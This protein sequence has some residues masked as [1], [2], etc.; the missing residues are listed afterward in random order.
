MQDGSRHD[1]A[2]STSS[3][4]LSVGLVNVQNH[5][6]LGDLAAGVLAVLTSAGGGAE[7]DGT[8]KAAK[9]AAAAS[10]QFASKWLR[11]A[12]TARGLV[13]IHVPGLGADHYTE[14][15]QLLPKL[16]KRFGSKLSVMLSP[17]GTTYYP[18]T[19]CYATCT[20]A[21]RPAAERGVGGTLKR[22]RDTAAEATDLTAEEG[23]APSAANGEP[24]VAVNAAVE[25]AQDDSSGDAPADGEVLPL[26]HLALTPLQMLEAGYPVPVAPSVPG[27]PPRCPPGYVASQPRN[28]LHGSKEKQTPRLFA[29]DCEM[30]CTDASGL[31]LARVTVLDSQGRAVLDRFV[32]PLHPV[33]DYVTRYS[34]VAPENLEGEPDDG[35]PSAAG[36]SSSLTSP[37]DQRPLSFARA[38]ACVLSLIAEDDVL[39]GHSLE[40]DLHALRLVHPCVIDTSCLYKSRRGPPFKPGLR[41]LC[42]SVLGRMIQQE[43]H[44]S[45]EDARAALHLVQHAARA[46]HLDVTGW[47]NALRNDRRI[48]PWYAPLGASAPEWSLG[49]SVLSIL[50]ALGTACDVIGSD[51]LV[52]RLTS[53]SS[54]VGRVV[55]R[56][57]HEGGVTAGDALGVAAANAQMSAAVAAVKRLARERLIADGEEGA[58]EDGGSS[59]DG[60]A[61][62]SS[63]SMP[64]WFAHVS[65]EALGHFWERRADRC[66][67]AVRGA[68][69]EAD[70][71]LG[72]SCTPMS[73]DEAMRDA[74]DVARRERQ[75]SATESL[76]HALAGIDGAI[77]DVCMALPRGVAVVVYSGQG[78]T[79]SA[80]LLQERRWDD[81][82][83]RAG[84]PLAGEMPGKRQ[85]GASN[86]SELTRVLNR[87]RRGL[88]L[89]KASDDWLA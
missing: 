46:M 25:G 43:N 78:D 36:N 9:E 17:S 61:S 49:P 71:R 76:K 22:M 23:G 63:L 72:A 29:M 87:A 59:G 47:F 44:D 26:A 18:A 75:R 86:E 70:M 5:T 32:K 13:A 79:P 37:H 56:A 69:D 31:E 45:A 51:A 41:E 62:C 53:T 80:R 38:R 39:V 65:L 11:K 15:A 40:S 66:R 33:V 28:L 42:E 73:R 85:W 68:A 34:G 81:T 52:T 19:A 54:G 82:G 35:D 16:H 10:T 7:D 3:T 1:K 83:L 48:S 20:R 2:S 55:I 30:I 14:L 12:G 27:E 58:A 4:R 77:D 8:C 24:A 50:R 60:V 88:C 74:S 67:A 6:R 57:E 84:K 21:K 89:I 64:T